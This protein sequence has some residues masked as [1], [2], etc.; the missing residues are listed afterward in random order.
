MLIETAEGVAVHQD[1]SAGLIKG[2]VSY[3]SSMFKGRELGT[4]FHVPHFSM[5]VR[6][7]AHQ[8]F[9][10]PG[11]VQVPDG[12]VVDLV[13][14]H[15]RPVLR[16]PE[17]RSPVLRG[18][19]DQVPISVVDHTRNRALVALEEDGPHCCCCGVGRR[20]LLGVSSDEAPSYGE[21]AS[22]AEFVAVAL[23]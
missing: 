19:E 15:S 9:R 7:T 4:T 16:Q 20:A 13:G 23:L 1:A 21:R 17:R 6:A 11:H 3:G 22:L 5:H 10:V 14:A 8:E 12:A 2:A 18:R